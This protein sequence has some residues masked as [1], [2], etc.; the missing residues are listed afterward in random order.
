MSLHRKAMSSP[1][2]A[3]V[4]TLILL[5]HPRVKCVLPPPDGIPLLGR[6]GGLLTNA[7]GNAGCRKTYRSISM[8]R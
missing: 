5:P 1:G 7:H 3:L 2:S 4:P 8:A 6:L